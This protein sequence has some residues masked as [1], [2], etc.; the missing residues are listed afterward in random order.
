VVVDLDAIAGNVRY[1][2]GLVSPGTAIMAVVKADA[3][4][5]GAV[6]VARAALEAGAACLAVATVEEGI[7]LREAG[8]AAPVL[9]LGPVDPS[10]VPTAVESD[11]TLA[12]AGMR[13]AQLVER[14]A[15]A[16]GRIGLPVHIKVDSGMRRFGALP[17]EAAAVAAY[18]ARSRSLRLAGIFT[19]FADA[20]A[21]E[22]AYTASQAATFEAVL[23]RLAAEQIRPPLVHAA[24]SAATLRWRAYD[25]DLVRIGIALYGLPPAPGFAMPAALRPALRVVSRVAR[26]IPLGAGEGVSYGLTYRAEREE[27]A[28]L[29][30]IGY[31]DGYP[32]ALSNRGWMAVGGRAAPVR[33]RVCMDQTMIG[34]P[35]GSVIRVGDEVEVL[36]GRG[37]S[38]AEVASAIGTIAYEVAT[39]LARRMQR[40]YESR[41]EK[42][43][44]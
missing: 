36:G 41:G 9:L 18:V 20:D 39:G 1:F 8:I 15:G 6:P 25:Y 4:G 5:H 27:E 16:V 33:G 11:L 31:A 35:D 30:P 17:D 44:D 3:Y 23:A 29:V 22:E 19:H 13:F 40:T 34:S 24:N 14:V 7:G 43:P 28:A 38:L 2:R 37:P 42:P 10:E 12:V 32:R 26:V 21:P